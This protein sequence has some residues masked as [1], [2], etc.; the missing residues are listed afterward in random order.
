MK[1]SHYDFIKRYSYETKKNR[2]WAKEYKVSVQ[3]INRW[4]RVYKTEIETEISKKTL[5]LQNQFE[6]YSILAL[7][8]LGDLLNSENENVKLNASK[9]ILQKTKYEEQNMPLLQPS[10]IL[11]FITPDDK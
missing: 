1:L 7:N 2:E 4:I 9:A 5:N 10:I 6:H 11:N 8:T 3:T